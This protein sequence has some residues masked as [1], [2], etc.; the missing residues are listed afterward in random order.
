MARDLA[1]GD[2]FSEGAVR[3]E[4]RAPQHAGEDAATGSGQD[5]VAR[6]VEAGGPSVGELI[7]QELAAADDEQGSQGIPI[8]RADVSVAGELQEK[9]V[10][11]ARAEDAYKRRDSGIYSA[12]KG[13][14]EKKALIKVAA[15]SFVA[16]TLLFGVI[17]PFG[18]VVGLKVRVPLYYDWVYGEGVVNNAKAAVAGK[19]KV[20]KKTAVTEQRAGR[21]GKENIEKGKPADKTAD[22][23]KVAAKEKPVNSG[24]AVEKKKKE[25]NEKKDNGTEPGH[26]TKKVAK[27]KRSSHKLE[28]QK[29]RSSRSRRNSYGRRSSYRTASRN[30]A[31]QHRQRTEP[32]SRRRSKIKRQAQKASVASADEGDFD[33]I[34]D[35]TP[36][37]PMGSKT[38]K[39]KGLRRRS[40]RRSKSRAAVEP[41]F[42][43][44]EED[45]KP[46]KKRHKVQPPPPPMPKQKKG[47]VLPDT[48]G[49]KVVLNGIKRGL[50]RIQRCAQEQLSR[51]KS[52]VVSKIVLGFTIQR[53]GRCTNISV[54]PSKVKGSYL[55]S[56]VKRSVRSWRYPK[57]FG[58]NIKVKIPLPL[59]VH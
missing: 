2:A 56:C 48:L 55:E 38:K 3:V 12:R 6:Q 24:G 22:N 40:S 42:G 46:R 28:K 31:P 37:V 29:N 54:G 43:D 10:P 25:E 35:D 1:K 32:V 8:A 53:S 52:A 17:I 19:G 15:V 59:N 23:E 7:Q 50:A 45:F 39:D 57:F 33:D 16:A 26:G 4:S 51:D 11:S 30:E 36:K 21:Q 34:L 58:E 44:D 27:S 9:V 18:L 14:P 47:A 5:A 20:S 49:K 41:D 13:E